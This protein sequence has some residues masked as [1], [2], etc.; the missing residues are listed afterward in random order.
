MIHNH[1]LRSG[2]MSELFI[3][4]SG[5]PVGW[6]RGVR[7][8]L[9][10]ADG[11]NEQFVSLPK[12]SYIFFR[13][14]PHSGPSDS[15]R[16]YSCPPIHVRAIHVRPYSCLTS[17]MSKRTDSCPDLFMSDPIH[18]RHIFDIFQRTDSCLAL[19]MSTRFMSYSTYSCMT[20]FRPGPIHVQD[21]ATK[22][23]HY[24]T[25]SLPNHKPDFY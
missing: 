9:G 2:I 5:Q 8:G 10:S 7:D 20:P 23:L 21:E 13:D 22:P 17:F 16:P 4:V 6:L 14:Y 12:P 3:L 24:Q 15:C 25:T 19:P 1:P 11:Q 18:V